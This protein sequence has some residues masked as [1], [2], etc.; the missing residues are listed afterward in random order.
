VTKMGWPWPLSAIEDWLKSKVSW[1]QDKLNS[2]KGKANDI[3]DRVDDD[4]WSYVRKI[5]SK[6]DA[7]LDKLDDINLDRVKSW[8]D[9]V[10]NSL[11]STVNQLKIA[12]SEVRTS[13]L[14]AIA[15]ARQ[16]ILSGIDTSLHSVDL[17]AFFWNFA[18]K[19]VNT[20][21]KLIEEALKE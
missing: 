17:A 13:L 3:W 4:I 20:V 7:I 12:V 21:L 14:G 6:A 18:V 11:I 2:I 5:R 15:E 8:L 16:S 9:S 10:R 1:I 19:N